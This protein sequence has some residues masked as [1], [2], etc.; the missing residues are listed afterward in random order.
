MAEF[1]LEADLIRDGWCLPLMALKGSGS[2]PPSLYGIAGHQ[3][4]RTEMIII[5]LI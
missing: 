2:P 4:I 3:D 5:L 1:A